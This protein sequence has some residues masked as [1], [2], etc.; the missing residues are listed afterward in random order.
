MVGV[1]SRAIDVFPGEM[2]AADIGTGETTD[3]ALRMLTKWNG[4][5]GFANNVG[6]V[7]PRRPGEGDVEGEGQSLERSPSST[8][9]DGLGDVR[10]FAAEEGGA[11]WESA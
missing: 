3:D 1:A 9:A 4:F 8:R 5:D 7:R 2:I 11:S 6:L 10:E